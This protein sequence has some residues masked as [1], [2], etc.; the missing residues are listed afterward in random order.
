[1]I[2]KHELGGIRSIL[3]KETNTEDASFLNLIV[4]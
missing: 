1:M 2:E 3:V 4:G